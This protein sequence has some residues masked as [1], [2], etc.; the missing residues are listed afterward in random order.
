MA[1]EV[2][3][4]VGEALSREAWKKAAARLTRYAGVVEQTIRKSCGDNVFE[5]FL[6]EIQMAA[7]AMLYVS[8]F[9][10]DKCRFIGAPAEY[11][12]RG[13]EGP[14]AVRTEEPKK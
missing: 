10:A 13:T 3:V 4:E 2:R 6:F 7:T 5:R 14:C 8:E 12:R 9:A 11:T 1:K